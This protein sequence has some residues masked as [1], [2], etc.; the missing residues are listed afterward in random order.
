MLCRRRLAAQ[1]NKSLIFF[2]I[3]GIIFIENEKESQNIAGWS[4]GRILGSF[5]KD[6]SSTL[7][8]APNSS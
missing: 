4:N 6:N 1:N 2:K 8:P 5:P 3:F 7:F